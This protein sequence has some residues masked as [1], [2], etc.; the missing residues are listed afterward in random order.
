MLS[1]V[2]R[3]ARAKP[4][5]GNINPAVARKLYAVAKGDAASNHVAARRAADNGVIVNDDD[6]VRNDEDPNDDNRTAD[7]DTPLFVGPR[8]V[9]AP[10][11]NTRGPQGRLVMVRDGVRLD[12]EPAA[13][14][15]DGAILYRVTSVVLPN[16]T[17]RV[18][19]LG[20]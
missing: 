10:T 2:Q 18:G 15:S 16:L 4:E 7:P 14:T 8:I 1:P 9:W 19:E 5:P 17:P 12:F 11:P 6:E 13:T 20:C 3:A